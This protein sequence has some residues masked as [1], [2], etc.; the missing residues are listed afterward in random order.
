M[1]IRTTDGESINS[2]HLST[3]KIDENTLIC[4]FK[5]LQDPIEFKMYPEEIEKFKEFARQSN[6]AE[7]GRM[8]GD[9]KI[10]EKVEFVA[11]ALGEI[12]YYIQSA[13][14][15]DPAG[16]VVANAMMFEDENAF[17]FIDPMADFDEVVYTAEDAIKAIDLLIE[18]INSGDLAD[19]KLGDI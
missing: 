12:K 3:F 16:S 11:Q 10:Q 4:R 1:W 18:V 6:L 17:G 9:L 19:I 14:L 15:L 7:R 8:A 13:M 2:D 5:G